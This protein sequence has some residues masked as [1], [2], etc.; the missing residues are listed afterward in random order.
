[1]LVLATALVLAG[2]TGAPGPDRRPSPAKVAPSG[3]AAAIEGRWTSESA[4]VDERP[5]IDLH[6]DGTLTGY[7]G[8]NGFSGLTWAADG[9]QVVVEG[10]ALRSLRGCS[11]IDQRPADVASLRPDAGTLVAVAA[12]GLTVGVLRTGE[13]APKAPTG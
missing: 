10:D 2:C 4:G 12:D 13:A 8:C 1:M 6:P 9:D 5:W 7:D 3:Q 11:G